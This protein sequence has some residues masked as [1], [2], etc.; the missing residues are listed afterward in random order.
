MIDPFARRVQNRPAQAILKEKYGSSYFLRQTPLEERYYA[1]AEIAHLAGR[2][3]AA[4]TMAIYAAIE[5]FAKEARAPFGFLRLYGM[6]DGD[7]RLARAIAVTLCIKV[8]ANKIAAK[9]EQDGGMGKE[10]IGR[11][12]LE[13][14]RSARYLKR[15]AKG[16]AFAELPDEEPKRS[17]YTA[18]RETRNDAGYLAGTEPSLSS[19]K[20]AMESI[21]KAMFGTDAVWMPDREN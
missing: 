7:S 6:A 15:R 20:K 1:L 2:K 8:G 9:M 13:W 18:L 12:V 16:I 21:A 14:D 11:H 3:R 5:G 17:F 10:E 19:E 4:T